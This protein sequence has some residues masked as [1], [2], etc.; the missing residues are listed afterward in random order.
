MWQNTHHLR[1][2]P[3]I[4]DSVERFTEFLAVLRKLLPGGAWEPVRNILEERKYVH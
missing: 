2:C 4:R 1:L 3:L